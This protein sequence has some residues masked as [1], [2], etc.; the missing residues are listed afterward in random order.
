MSDASSPQPPQ[1]DGPTANDVAGMAWWGALSEVKRLFW[2]TQAAGSAAGAS[3]ASA[4]AAFKH[5]D[6]EQAEHRE[7]QRKGQQ[8][9][10]HDDEQDGHGG[11]HRARGAGPR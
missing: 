11:G 3:A 6:P 5:A 8:A 10:R 7:G 2:L 4:W 9:A 1:D